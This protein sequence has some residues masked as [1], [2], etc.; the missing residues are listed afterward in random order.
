MYLCPIIQSASCHRPTAQLDTGFLAPR[1]KGP[2]LPLPPTPACNELALKRTRARRP[3]E[4]RPGASAPL[5]VCSRCTPAQGRPFQP[6]CSPRSR[7]SHTSW[8]GQRRVHSS[9]LPSPARAPGT[10]TRSQG[11]HTVLPQG[12]DVL[13]QFRATSPGLF[14]FKQCFSVFAPSLFAARSA[15]GPVPPHH[16]LTA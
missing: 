12:T 4:H 1:R 15:K 9:L 5:S 13:C 10:S 11:S 16:T 2:G 8:A 14:P 3:R 7:G 6:Q